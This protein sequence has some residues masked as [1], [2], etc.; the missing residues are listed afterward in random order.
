MEK[1]GEWPEEKLEE[2][3]GGFAAIEEGERLDESCFRRCIAGDERL[4]SIDGSMVA[5]NEAML[6][7]YICSRWEFVMGSS[8][9]IGS[10]EGC[11]R[12][13]EEHEGE[14]DTSKDSYQ[15]KGPLPTYSMCNFP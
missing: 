5:G 7:V 3:V 4:L 9:R 2:R 13:K 12:A 10:W 6:L 14:E 1:E 15:V 11:F 8:W